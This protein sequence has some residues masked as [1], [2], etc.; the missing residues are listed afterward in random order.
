MT[1]P[2]GT[3]VPSAPG[4]GHLPG[5]RNLQQTAAERPVS[6]NSGPALYA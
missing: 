3:T 6:N 1:G 2:N 4:A 5:M